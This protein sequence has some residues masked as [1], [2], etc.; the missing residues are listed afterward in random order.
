[1]SLL[2]V[3]CFETSARLDAVS[4][5]LLKHCQQTMLVCLGMLLVVDIQ[6]SASFFSVLYCLI[7]FR[8]PVK[9]VLLLRLP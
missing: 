5:W 2:V 6:F 9:A 3:T 1:M 7:P 4:A 8:I